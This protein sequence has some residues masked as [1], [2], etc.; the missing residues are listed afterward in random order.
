MDLRGVQTVLLAG[1]GSDDE[2]LMRVFGDPLRRIGA[3]PRAVRPTP[4]ALVAGYRAALSAAADDGP[5]AVAG[6][7]LG[8]A[9]AADWA[10]AHPGRVLAV[11]AALPPWTGAPGDAPGALSARHT[12]E[13]LRRDGLAAT[14][15]AMRCSSPEWLAEEL[16]RSW[17]RQW[18]DLPDAL[19][20]AAGF[21]A[22]TVAALGG[23]TAPMGVAGA[24]DDPIHPLAVARAWAAAAPRAALR[25]VT[26]SRFGPYPAALGAA[27]VGALA[28]VG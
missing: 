24:P 3:V 6:V 14:T 10:L 16:T 15:E 21:D 25:T 26:L 4:T 27:C 12:A 17:Q 28:A 11:L 5:I 19:E 2:Y 23:L 22:P 13:Q 18:P 7:S 1:T 9:V 8:A 20:E